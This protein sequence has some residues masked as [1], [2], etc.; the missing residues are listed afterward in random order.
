MLVPML[1]GLTK[2]VLQFQFKRASVNVFSHKLI[3]HYVFFKTQDTDRYQFAIAAR[4]VA[5]LEN[6]ELTTM[7]SVI[8]ALMVF[9]AL[10]CLVLR[11]FSK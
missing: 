6:V 7:V 9:T 8:V 10:F 2:G 11:L 1:L 5:I 3:I 4:G